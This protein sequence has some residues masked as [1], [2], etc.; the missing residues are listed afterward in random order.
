MAVCY[1]HAYRNPRH[2]ADTG[3]AVARGLKGVYVSLSSEV[4][5][6]IKESS[7][8]GPR[9]STRTWAPR[10]PVTW[11]AWP[12]GCARTASPGMC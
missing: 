8:C 10:W 1:L 7:A 12:P 3:R 4:L 2:E 5:P 11:P 6:Q 9:W